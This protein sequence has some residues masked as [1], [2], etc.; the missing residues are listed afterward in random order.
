[1][2]TITL[3]RDEGWRYRTQDGILVSFEECTIGK[4]KGKLF[5]TVYSEYTQY[6]ETLKDNIVG[7]KEDYLLEVTTQIRYHDQP[8]VLS[9]GTVRVL[10]E[11]EVDERKYSTTEVFFDIARA[12]KFA[13]EEGNVYPGYTFNRYWNG[14]DCPYFTKET[15][16]EI[17]NEYEVCFYE[18]ETD[19][20]YC[21]GDYGKEEIGLPTE[22]NTPDGKLKVYDFGVAGWIWSE[23]EERDED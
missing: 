11:I 7:T 17:C 5:M 8:K 14:W 18:E 23:V 2:K 12:A 16:L 6:V 20:F 10:K 21:N 4:Y 19:T 9:N 3:T 15:A 1:M 13:I 22:I